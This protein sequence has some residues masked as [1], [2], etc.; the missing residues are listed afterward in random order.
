MS[1]TVSVGKHSFIDSRQPYNKRCP[2]PKYF[3]EDIL[4]EELPTSKEDIL[5][6]LIEGH[7]GGLVCID[8]EAMDR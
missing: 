3:T 2:P 7:H 4:L 6:G 1:D 8:Q 5:R